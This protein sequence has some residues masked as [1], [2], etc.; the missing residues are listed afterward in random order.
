SRIASMIGSGVSSVLPANPMPAAPRR[1]GVPRA[2]LGQTA[3]HSARRR[4]FPQD[5][6]PVGDGDV[7]LHSWISS[8]TGDPR[9]TLMPLLKV[10]PISLPSDLGAGTLSSVYL[11]TPVRLKKVWLILTLSIEPTSTSP[12]RPS[13]PWAGSMRWKTCTSS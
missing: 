2:D 12:T 11:N 8:D 1:K 7:R 4:W 3:S 9:V 10:T 6:V 5:D 13:P